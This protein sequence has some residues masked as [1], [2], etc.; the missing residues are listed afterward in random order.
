MD[1]RVHDVLDEP[2]FGPA[3]RAAMRDQ[4]RKLR[5][6]GSLVLS[7][8]VLLG[9]VELATGRR[10]PLVV[11][12]LALTALVVVVLV[13]RRAYRASVTALRATP[14]YGQPREVRLTDERVE[15]TTPVTHAEVAW[16]TIATAREH[17]GIL[18][19]GHGR[20][21]IPVTT[22]DLSHGEAAELRA[23][24]AGRGFVVA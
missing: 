16:S 11:Y 22:R 4:L 5:L 9:A 6:Y 15:I 8:A 2:T 21:V 14:G 23:F 19:L 17:D 24:L 12:A 7:G 20:T 18:L 10:P 1:I 3:I 13:P